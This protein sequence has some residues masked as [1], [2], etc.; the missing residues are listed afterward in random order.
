MTMLTNL[1]V[2]G[3]AFLCTLVTT[4]AVKALANRFELLDLPDERK[5]HQ[6]RTPTLGGAAI[7]FG[8]LVGV[9]IYVIFSAHRISSDMVGILAGATIIFVFGVI[10][11]TRGL[12][13]LSKL[14][15]QVLA[16]GALL[17]M[18]VQIQNL[19][20]PW[21]GM[22]SLS[23]ELS[24]VISLIWVV[25]FMN[26]INLIDGLDGL[27]AGITFIAALSMFFYIVYTGVGGVFGEAA[28][29]SAIIA[30]TTLG[31]LPY[32]FNP[33]KIFMGDS[34][35]MLLGFLLGAVTIQG[36]LKSIGA[37][38]IAAP[39]MALAVPIFD[40]GMAIFRRVF[41]GRSITGA[42]K[43]HIHHRLLEMGHTHK[44][45]VLLLYLWTGLFC[46]LILLL[47]FKVESK[48]IW[49]IPVVGVVALALTL[50][51]LVSRRKNHA[52]HRE[53]FEGE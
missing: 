9:V 32:N 14:F 45:A 1:I 16:A 23:P 13:P 41:K 37:I 8:F 52:K 5:I 53:H 50:F 39:L 48:Y 46:A 12:S 6:D 11:D 42:D 44:R 38:A 36:V 10:D 34:G 17:V 25:A 26:I 40:T 47:K 2:F 35:S 20:I 15:G 28:V 21:L 24:A 30:G 19:H 3:I 7:Y 22:V 27:A 43:E 29:V 33:A 51:P 4:P 31:F 49:L 18:G